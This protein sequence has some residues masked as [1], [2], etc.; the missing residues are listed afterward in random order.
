MVQL[1]VVLAMVVRQFD[2]T[3]AYDE[4][5][6]LHDVGKKSVGSAM[7]PPRTYRGERAY[8]IEVGAS[9]P[10][11]LMPCRVKLAEPGKVE[12]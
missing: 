6:A 9:H 7:G 3:V 11:E 8:Q 2:F 12:E 1:R 5:D 10:A 4:W